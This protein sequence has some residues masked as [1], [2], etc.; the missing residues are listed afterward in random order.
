MTRKLSVLLGLGLVIAIILSACQATPAEPTVDLQG[1]V[2]TSVAQTLAAHA[3]NPTENPLPTSMFPTATLL[4]SATPKPTLQTLPTYQPPVPT[5]LPCL[6]MNITDITVPDNTKF[7]PGTAFTK[8][9]RLYN[10]GSCTWPKTF[11]VFFF[12]GDQLAAP[13]SVALSR[14]VLSGSS[15]DVSVNMVAPTNEGTYKSN[16]K[17]KTPNGTV[18][19]SGNSSVPFFAQIIVQNIPFAVS[20]V[21]ISVDDA[22]PATNLCATGHTFNF[23]A[24]ITATAAGTVTYHWIQPDGLTSAIYSLDFAAAGT[25]SATPLA[26]PLLASTTSPGSVSVDIVT[27]NNQIFGPGGSFSYTCTP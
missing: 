5:T 20:N 8:T 18:F 15:I 11:V 9:W 19:G 27:P 3:T 22:A 25:K 13:A 7:A 1:L 10:D 2:S 24:A 14:D 23:T 21:V 16:W 26:W 4:P 17:M 6:H 12:G